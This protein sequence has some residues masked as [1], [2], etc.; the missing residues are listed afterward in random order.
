[1]HTGTCW[2]LS[3]LVPLLALVHWVICSVLLLGGSRYRRLIWCHNRSGRYD[4]FEHSKYLWQLFLTRNAICMQSHKQRT[5]RP[6]SYIP[7]NEFIGWERRLY[8]WAVFSTI[9]LFLF[10]LIY[11]FVRAPSEP[12]SR[13]AESWDP[14]LRIPQFLPPPP[15]YTSKGHQIYLKEAFRL[16]SLTRVLLCLV[17]V[18]VPRVSWAVRYLDKLQWRAVKRLELGQQYF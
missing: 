15:L 1:M 5:K 16:A 6:Y 2:Q 18:D 11:I 4:N 14:E 12:K 9:L 7:I 10:S 3:S 17:R 8:F 13:V